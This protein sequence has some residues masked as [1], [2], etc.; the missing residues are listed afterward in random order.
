MNLQSEKENLIKLIDQ[1]SDLSII[2][3]I[4]KLFKSEKKDFWHELTEEHQKEINL[5]LKEFDEGKYSNFENF[6]KKYI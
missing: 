2:S 1:T 3:S 6:I 5:S 4:K